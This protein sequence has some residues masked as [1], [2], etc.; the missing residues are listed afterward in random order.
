MTDLHP[1]ELIGRYPLKALGITAGAVLI[2]LG[3]VWALGYAMGQRKQAI[4]TTE[5]ENRANVEKGKA[6][7]N[8]AQAVQATA[9]AVAADQARLEFQNKAKA[10]NALVAQKNAELA[11]L[12]A[13]LAASHQP[14]VDGTPG[15][16]NAY[17]KA[18]E[19]IEVQKADKAID[20]EKIEALGRGIEL[21]KASSKSWQASAEARE[22]E[23][24]GLRIALEAQKSLT[25]GA[26]W[27]GRLQGLAVGVASGY[28]VGRAH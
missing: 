13:D 1:D 6:D 9:Q 18:L 8:Q 21:W 25:R 19:V 17:A 15:L 27:K 4:A 3:S 16:A 23:A 24:A 20:Q 5:A 26:L 12:Q 7:A 28:L 2:I 14:V 11:K 10:S 22:Q